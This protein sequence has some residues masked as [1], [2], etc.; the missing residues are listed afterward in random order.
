VTLGYCLVCE[1][2]V[3][4]R[5]GDYRGL[6]RQRLWYPVTHV[7]PDGVTLCEGSSKGI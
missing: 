1:K 6:G 3:P 5:P 2:L 4:I 7:K